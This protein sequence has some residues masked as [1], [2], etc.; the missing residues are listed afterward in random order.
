MNMRGI[1]V[2]I[3]VVV[4]GALLITS[5]DTQNEPPTVRIISPDEGVIH[6]GELKFE[7]DI[8]DAE[9]DEFTV[10]WDFGDGTNST[11][12]APVHMYQQ[13]NQYRV[14][15]SVRSGGSE[16]ARDAVVI[17]VQTGPTAIVSVGRIDPDANSSRNTVIQFISDEAPLRVEFIGSL[18]RAEPGT[19]IASYQWDF[20]TG[21][22]STE[23]NPTYVYEDAGEYEA[24]LTISDSNGRESQATATVRVISYEPV[25]ETIELADVSISFE[26]HET[27]NNESDNA[28]FSQYIIDTPRTLTEVELRE[29][30]SNIIEKSKDR[31]RVSKISVFLYTQ[32]KKEFMAPREYAHYMGYGIWIRDALDQEPS[33]TLNQSY[34]N[35]TGK[36]VLGFVINEA[37]LFPGDVDCG[38]VC[39]EHRIGLAE[40]Y[41]DDPDFCDDLLDET[42]LEI[43]EWRLNATYD[44]YLIRIFNL[45]DI[46]EPIAR[47]AGVRPDGATLEEL[48]YNL[49]RDP[50]TNWSDPKSD[51]LRIN[52]EPGIP[53]CS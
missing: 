24:I 51:R 37:M 32:D 49:F 25:R 10:E 53:A 15:V 36:E 4:F 44:G 16:V 9:G 6:P 2:S 33:I 46:S 28:V 42:L 17:D 26:L 35:G 43:A 30:I 29:L 8:Q 52:Y 14:E 50:P 7:V 11:E 13:S 48:P 40:I 3:I 12:M 20:G 1:V 31:P 39:S 34:L 22:G 5:C 21:D 41:I 23:P 47:M 19:E 27:N 18:S 38:E 45:E